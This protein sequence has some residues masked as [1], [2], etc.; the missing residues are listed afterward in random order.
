MAQ[1]TFDTE[2]IRDFGQD[3]SVS[4]NGLDIELLRLENAA[5][6]LRG[7]WSGEAQQAFDS[8]QLEW[9]TSMRALK[10]ILQAVSDLCDFAAQT[11][12]ETEDALED[13]YAAA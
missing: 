6:V 9:A 2:R 13:V 12:E 3:L 7:A 1:L 10:T 8:A 5:L 11:Y 4:V